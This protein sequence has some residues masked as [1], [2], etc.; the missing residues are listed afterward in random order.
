MFWAWSSVQWVRSTLRTQQ[1]WGNCMLSI[2]VTAKIS[3]ADLQDW[4][5]FF[6]FEG[7]SHRIVM[8]NVID[9]DVILSEFELQSRY[10]SL[11]DK[12]SWNKYEPPYP[13]QLHCSSIRMSLALNN[14]QSLICHYGCA[15]RVIVIV[16]GNG[17][18]DP[19]SNPGRDWLHFT[20]H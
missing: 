1:V 5:T 11:F 16:G 14:P 20:Q 9:C 12:Y 13:R 10:N 4:Q 8:A 7:G 18:G 2:N 17:H 3:N 6:R 15:R 19:S